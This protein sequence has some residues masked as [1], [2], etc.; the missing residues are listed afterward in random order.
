MDV[1]GFAA[2]LHTQPLR[3]STPA[4]YITRMRSIANWAGAAG[5]DLRTCTPSQLVPL[6]AATPNSYSSRVL[7]KAVLKWWWV[8]TERAD[9]PLSVVVVPPKPQ[10]SCRA[11][12]PDVAHLLAE[13]AWGRHPE[14]TAVLSGFYLGIRISEIA[15]MEWSR[16]GEDWYHVLGK[17]LKERYV[18]VAR[19]LQVHLRN[20]EQEDPRWVFPGAGKQ[21]YVH[22]STV[23]KW[24]QK[25]AREAGVPP[26]APHRM[27]HTFGATLNDKTRDFRTTQ[28]LMGHS[29]PKTTALYTMTSRRRMRSAIDVLDFQ[30]DPDSAGSA[31]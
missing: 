24:V 8:F 18:P 29:D 12:S 13:V 14:G 11:L 20:V 15:A 5:V 1:D 3:G 25:L 30:A 6:V 10:Y 7:L 16:F 4:T 22:R 27:R 23:W 21:P 26:V 28:E 31:A 2:W 17:G 19:S 9:P